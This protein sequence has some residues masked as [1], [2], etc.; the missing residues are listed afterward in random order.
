MGR[1]RLHTCVSAGLQR[2]VARRP[3]PARLLEPASNGGFGETGGDRRDTRTA[4]CIPPRGLL[5]RCCDLER[6]LSMRTAADQQRLAASLFGRASSLRPARNGGSDADSA[7]EQ[8]QPSP[9]CSSCAD[10]IPRPRPPTR[11][12]RSRS[13]RST[14]ARS[15]TCVSSDVID[16]GTR[17][18]GSA[19]LL[20][21]AGNRGFDVASSISRGRL[22]GAANT[23]DVGRS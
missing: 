18:P 1:R 17:P 6:L 14:R 2:S 10:P 16:F 19:R 15:S 5:S 11:A 9:C 3:G 22:P 4:H 23:H 13:R 8:A 21:P 7:D 20:E 12:E